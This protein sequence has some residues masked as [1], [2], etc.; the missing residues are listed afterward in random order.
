MR[1]DTLLVVLALL[2]AAIVHLGV[3]TGAGGAVP[4]TPS[5]PWPTL[6]DHDRSCRPCGLVARP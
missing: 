6:G 5:L 1:E 2:V 3:S 4:A